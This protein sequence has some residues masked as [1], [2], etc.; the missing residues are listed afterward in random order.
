M[1]RTL[2]GAQAACRYCAPHVV[3]GAR[4]LDRLESLRLAAGR[5]ALA[6]VTLAAASVEKGQLYAK[7]SPTASSSA[8]RAKAIAYGRMERA[9]QAREAALRAYLDA[10]RAGVAQ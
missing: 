9:L 8:K 6:Y 10:V 5:T 4:P 2:V 7:S 1:S 3:G